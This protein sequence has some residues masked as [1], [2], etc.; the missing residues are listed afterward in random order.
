MRAGEGEAG[1]DATSKDSTTLL[2]LVFLIVML[3]VPAWMGSSKVATRF[4]PTGTF[5][6]LSAGI[7]PM[8]TGGVM[9]PPLLFCFNV[10]PVMVPPELFASEI[11]IDPKFCAVVKV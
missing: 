6:A 4:A 9:S 7:V 3:P 10:K 2:S 5:E 8:R 1:E 11:R